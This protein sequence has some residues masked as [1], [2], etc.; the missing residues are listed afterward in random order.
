MCNYIPLLIKVQFWPRGKFEPGT[1]I[2]SE[3]ELMPLEI[4]RS[5]AFGGSCLMDTFFFQLPSNF[6]S[7]YSASLITQFSYKTSSYTNFYF[8]SLFSTKPV[9]ASF[10]Y[11]PPLGQPPGTPCTW[12]LAFES[13]WKSLQFFVLNG[14]AATGPEATSSPCG[15][16]SAAVSAGIG[17]AGPLC[18][19]KLCVDSLWWGNILRHFL[20]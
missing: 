14:I 7:F 2:W 1:V 4:A 8:S 11:V 6:S 16:N 17:V 12:R 13:A 19:K 5:S 10:F 20:M 3:F 15:C 9:W 18:L